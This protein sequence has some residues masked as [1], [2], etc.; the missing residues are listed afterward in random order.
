MK[1]IDNWQRAWR[2]SSVRAAVLLLVLS[3]L[4]GLQADVLPLVQGLVKPE[5]WPW[6]SAAFATAIVVFRVLRQVAA[7]DP[8][9]RDPDLPPPAAAPGEETRS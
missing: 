6:V 4:Q 2:L 5:H 7:L 8:T 1:L 9:E 3:L